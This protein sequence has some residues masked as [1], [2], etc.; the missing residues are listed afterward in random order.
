[1]ALW[2]RGPPLP[3]MEAADPWIVVRPG[4]KKRGGRKGSCRVTLSSLCEENLALLRQ[5]CVGVQAQCTG[6]FFVVRDAATDPEATLR[7]LSHACNVAS[8]S[9]ACLVCRDEPSLAAYTARICSSVVQQMSSEQALVFALKLR[10]ISLKL[11]PVHPQ[12]LF[13]SVIAMLEQRG[14]R[15][16][17]S[18]SCVIHIEV[19]P[20]LCYQRISHSCVMKMGDFVR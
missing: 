14:W 19:S 10:C 11:L 4:S 3:C 2:N 5:L 20:S 16:A 18:L 7:R 6:D 12:L 13:A 9:R 1:M 17:A 15:H 8:V